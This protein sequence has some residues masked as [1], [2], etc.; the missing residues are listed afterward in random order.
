MTGIKSDINR[1]GLEIT[2]LSTEARKGTSYFE[3]LSLALHPSYF[4]PYIMW[5]YHFGIIPP[6]LLGIW[7]KII[8]IDMLF[9][10]ETTT[11]KWINPNK[12]WIAYSETPVHSE[13][14]RSTLVRGHWLSLR[15][16]TSLILQCSVIL[17]NWHKLSFKRSWKARPCL[18]SFFTIGL[19]THILLWCN[20]WIAC[21]LRQASTTKQKR[22]QA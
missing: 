17:V 12:S 10:I 5:C 22:W 8:Y 14:Q 19:A 4:N 1:V 11:G 15:A 16:P 7:K 3:G 13:S 18:E 6:K 2:T 21:R 20:I 9:R